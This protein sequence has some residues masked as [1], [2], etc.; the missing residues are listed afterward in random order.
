[1]SEN[2]SFIYIGISKHYSRYKVWGPTT[3]YKKYQV[4]LEC[5]VRTNSQSKLAV[6]A[7]MHFR[8]RDFCPRGTHHRALNTHNI[9]F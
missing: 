9:S 4:K 2:I 3:I 8:T 1:M 6:F 7:K 5:V